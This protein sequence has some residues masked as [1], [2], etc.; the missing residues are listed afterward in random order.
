MRKR[1]LFCVALVAF[2][3]SA[4]SSR[5]IGQQAPAGRQGGPGAPGGR[6]GGPP[7]V[8]LP[9]GAGREQVQ[10]TCTKCHGLNQIQN[11]WGYTKDGWQDRIATMVKL[12]ASDLEAIS[13]YLATHYP[14]KGA[15]G[16]VLISGP[17]TVTIKEWMAPT[18]GSRP[19]DSHAAADGSIWWTGMY[20]SKLGRLD[21]RTGAIREFDVQSQ[22]HGLAEDP[23]G[24]MWFTGI[25]K[26]VIGRLDPKTGQVKEYPITEP[27]ARAPHTP[28]LDKRSGNLF[29]TLQSGHVGRLNTATGEMVIKKTPSDNSY[30]Y[31]IRLNSQGVPWYVDFRGNRVGSVDPRTMEIKEYA[32]P[33]ADARPRRL[34]IT[35]D[36]VVWYTD[37]PRGMLGRF[38]PKSGQVKEWPSPG[39]KSSEPYAITSI[40][41]VIWYSESGVRPNT[42]VRF[43]TQTEK[44]QTFAIPSGGGVLRHF[45][46]TAQGNIVTANS[47]V[48]KI[49][50]VE[51]GTLSAPRTN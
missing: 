42:M 1:A 19:H 26:S 11:S 20:A 16:A 13:S 3:A 37:F 33:N 38:D 6:Q 50:L 23:Q 12:P 34:T 27:G 32:L 17:A 31:G 48:N 51:I 29:F 36:D 21:P 46:A 24:N 43:D 35:A 49:G 7:A 10:A 41:N 30:P 28:I 39:G 5:A 45:E 14:I 22:P 18:L 40:G 4:L 9:E 2:L 15:P 25:Q 47:G 44:F 8:Q